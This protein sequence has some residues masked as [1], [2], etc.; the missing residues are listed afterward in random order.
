MTLFFAS[1]CGV[2]LVI[3]GAF[4]WRGIQDGKDHDRLYDKYCDADRERFR[5]RIDKDALE[6]EITVL[7]ESNRSSLKAWQTE[8]RRLQAKIRAS[9]THAQEL[10]DFHLYNEQDLQHELAGTHA[11]IELLMM[12]IPKGEVLTHKFEV[13]RLFRTVAEARPKI[14]TPGCTKYPDKPGIF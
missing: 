9:E 6:K 3:V 10:Q 12:A 7:R 8:R 11:L 13:Q 1:L 5:L 4:V 2:L 14:N